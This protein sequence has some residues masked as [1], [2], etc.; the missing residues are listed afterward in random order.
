LLYGAYSYL[1]FEGDRKIRPGFKV[2]NSAA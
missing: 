1:G 2:S